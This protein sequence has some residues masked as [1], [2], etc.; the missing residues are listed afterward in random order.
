MS[1][2]NFNIPLV[3]A[4]TKYMFLVRNVKYYNHLNF[5]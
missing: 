2:E 4:K 1:L 5:L 3:Q